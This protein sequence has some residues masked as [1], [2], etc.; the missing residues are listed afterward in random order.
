MSA[1]TCSGLS[2]RP[3]AM[4]RTNWLKTLSPTLAIASRW[5]GVNLVSVKAF[6]AFLYS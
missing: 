1:L 5:A 6:I 2:L 4:P 3:S